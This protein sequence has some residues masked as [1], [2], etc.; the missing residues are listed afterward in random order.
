[1]SQMRFAAGFIAAAMFSVSCTSM[2]GP[3]AGYVPSNP[4]MLCDVSSSTFNNDWAKITLPIGKDGL[5]IGPFFD[6]N[7]GIVYVFPADGPD[8]SSANDCEFFE[9]STQMFMWLTSSISDGETPSSSATL[10]PTGIDT[11]Y[12]FSSEFFYRLSDDGLLVPQSHGG[13]APLRHVRFRKSDDGLASIA[14]AGGNGVLFTQADTN[15]SKESS[16]IYYD[17]LTNRPFGYVADAVL[18]KAPAP[19]NYS[20]FVENTDQ[21]CNAIKYGLD[22]GFVDNEGQTAAF[23]YNLFCPQDKVSV[24]GIPTLPTSIPQLETAI[25]FLSMNMEVKVAW[26][27]ASTLEHPERYITQKGS[28]PI[29]SNVDGKNEMIHM[30][31]KNADL[32]MV[33][34]HVVGSVNGHPEMIWATF[35]HVDNAPNATYY[36]VDASG[37]TTSQTDTSST[38]NK[39]WL[40]SDGTAVSDITEYGVSYVDPDSSVN[41]IKPATKDQTAAVSTPSNVNRINPWGSVQG[42]GSEESNTEVISTNVSALKNL[43]DFYSSQGLKNVKDARFNYMLTGASWGMDGQ[44]PSGEKASQISGTVAMANTTMET[45]Q[46]TY[47]QSNGDNTGCFSC[48]GI[49]AGDRKFGASHIFRKITEVKK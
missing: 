47:L 14:Q 9:W 38:A 41:Y 6:K 12:V 4:K 31:N 23:L 34:M 37:N 13:P 5:P 3:L 20:E 30:W 16:L 46:Q 29:F 7:S 18:N 22:N 48:H 17:V 28:I 42:E 11:P 49:E 44:F 36:Y 1:M 39:K 45:F 24:N 10:E 35:E 8:F 32:A 33:G 19:N 26:V 40:F 15:V 43:Q 21:T 27:D 25:D 2:A